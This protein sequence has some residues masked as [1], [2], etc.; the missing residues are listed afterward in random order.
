MTNVVL[1]A[2]AYKGRHA[3]YDLLNGMCTAEGCAAQAS[4]DAPVP[5]CPNHMR[6]AFAHYLI[7][8]EGRAAEVAELDMYEDEPTQ[9][10]RTSVLT[11]V[12]FVYFVRFSDRIKIG[13]SGNPG[14]RLK[15][16]PHDEVL[17]IIPG[18]MLDERKLHAAFARHRVVGEW[19]ELNQDL[20]DFI[21]DLTQPA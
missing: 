10:Y 6:V 18:T 3:D 19:F 15:N 20:L 4:E 8:I 14:A 17:A 1:R 12:G 2:H 21:A 5:L 13:W 9:A 7:S 11:T 16:V